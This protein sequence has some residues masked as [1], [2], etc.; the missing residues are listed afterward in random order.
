MSEVCS[1]RPPARRGIVI[2]LASLL[3]AVLA[4]SGRATA[5]DL[6][7]Q[8]EHKRQG[9][10]QAEEQKGVLSDQLGRLSDQVDGLR[11]EVATLRN[12]EA[13]VAE[14][15]ARTE[16]RLERAKEELVELRAR[17]HRALRVLR[18]RLVAIYKSDEPDALTVILNSDGFDDLLDRYSYLTSIEEQDAA[19]AGR[20]R[21]LRAET[22]DMVD[23]VRRARD[24]IEA[25]QAE[26]ARTRSELETRQAELVATQERQQG[27]LREVQSRARVLE[28]DVSDLQAEVQAQIQ[29]AQ[30][31]AEE[32]AQA[33]G[34][35]PPPAGPVPGESSSGLIWPVNGAI[36]SPFGMRWGRMHE[37]IDIA[38]PGG[39]PIR[40]AASGRVILAAYTGG[41]GNYTCLDHGQGLSTCY[42]H[43]SGYAVS[44][45]DSVS[46]G[47]VIGYVGNT[48]ASFG[49]HLHFEV[50]V[51]GQAVD[52]MGYL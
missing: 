26:L 7:S 22:R 19:V 25:K 13:A 41:Y 47:Q 3:G 48:G 2:A 45:G 40:A 51:G 24:E 49:D 35:A 27:A 20:V 6:Q 12:R 10:E 18:Q 8:L 43:Q 28:A 21:D 9:L 17:L 23:F 11:A 16:A 33:S 14:E 30:A 39:T 37:G 44:Q 32:E 36:S 50:R 46:Q 42:A 5:Q 38:A 31:A 15:L 4:L 1:S 29:A 34:V 52:P